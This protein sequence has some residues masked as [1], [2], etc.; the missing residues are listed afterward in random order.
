MKPR[1]VKFPFKSRLSLSPLLDFWEH[2]L[3]EGAGGMSSLGPDIRAKIDSALELRSP[4]QDLTLLEK[5][6]ELIE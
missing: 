5:H 6:Q 3:A 2:L 4:I 1:K